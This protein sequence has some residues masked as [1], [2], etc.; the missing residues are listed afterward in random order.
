MCNSTRLL[1]HIRPDLAASQ[2]GRL[3]SAHLV[4]FLFTLEAWAVLWGSHLPAGQLSV[5]VVSWRSRR[6]KLL[7]DPLCSAFHS[8]PFFS[9]N[10]LLPLVSLPDF[11]GNHFMVKHS[12]SFWVP[13]LTSWSS[14]FS[15][16]RRNLCYYRHYL[17]L[18]VPGNGQNSN[19]IIWRWMF[20][21]WKQ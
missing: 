7:S 5:T 6:Q 18:I 1:D 11:S 14:H 20:R 16:F 19:T 3:L 17:E 13:F 10:P 12:Q 2:G 4:H 9:F 8:Q 21:G 15:N